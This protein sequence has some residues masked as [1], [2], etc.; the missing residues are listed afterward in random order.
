MVPSA[1][2]SPSW[3]I[4][5]TVGM[6]PLSTPPVGAPR[7][8]DIVG[9]GQDRLLER[10]RVRHVRIGR[11]QADDRAVQ[12]LEAFLDDERRHFGADAAGLVVLVQDQHF[13]GLAPRSPRSLRFE[14]QQRAQVEDLDRDALG[15]QRVAGLERQMHA[16]A[17]GDDAQVACPARSRSALPIG[18]GVVLVG[19]FAAQAAVALLVLEEQD[20]V[21]VADRA[22][23]QALAVV[24]GARDDDLQ[25]GDVEEQRLDAL[26][27]VQAAVHAGA[28]RRS[29]DDR[30]PKA[31]FER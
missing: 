30:T 26:R 11:G 25:A 20:R 31:P 6:R 16:D 15:G 8:T 14:R 13:A 18:I 7:R 23:Q 27:V 9:V 10:G 24:R 1:T 17:V 22:L 21:V 28:E 12:L 5:M 2:D 19:D 29:E 3:G 4:L